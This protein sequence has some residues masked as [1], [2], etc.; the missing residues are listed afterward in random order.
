MGA[1]FGEWPNEDPAIVP[2]RAVSELEDCIVQDEY[3]VRS[4]SAMQLHEPSATL[5]AELFSFATCRGDHRAAEV[6]QRGATEHGGANGHDARCTARERGE[7]ITC[8]AEPI[9][10]RQMRHAGKVGAHV[11][12]NW[13]DSGDV[14][15]RIAS[16]VALRRGLLENA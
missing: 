3:Q 10:V 2:L 5:L 6:I 14:H 12:K 16:I 15:R 11:S 8:G 9:I 1:R 7:R 4:G 13:I